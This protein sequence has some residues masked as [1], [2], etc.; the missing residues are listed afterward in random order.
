MH[1]T[2]GWPVKDNLGVRCLL[3]PH[4]AGEH[5]GDPSTEKQLAEWFERLRLVSQSAT[6]TNIEPWDIGAFLLTLNAWA[7]QGANTKHSRCKS[8]GVLQPEAYT[9][10]DAECMLALLVRATAINPKNAVRP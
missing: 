1:D 10:H 2:C 5:D 8:C 7:N 4:H 6:A 3:R 9:V